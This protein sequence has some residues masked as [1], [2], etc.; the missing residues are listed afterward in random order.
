MRLSRSAW[1][2]L[3]S[4]ACVLAVAGCGRGTPKERN[5][6]EERLYRIG[7]AYLQ[8]CYRLG[9]AP[10]NFEDIKDSIEGDIPDDLLVSPRDGENF[11]IFWGVDFSKLR[12]ARENPFTV[13]GYE[14]HGIDGTRYVLRFPIGVVPMTDEE[15]HQAIF[16]PGYKAPN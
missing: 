10:A 1:R 11:V 3:I 14:K 8:T 9:E 13:A 4:S 6:T 2:W 16:P 15:L 5:V 7:K 12:P